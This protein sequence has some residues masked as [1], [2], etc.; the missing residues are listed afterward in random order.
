[1]ERYNKKRAIVFNT[2]QLYRHD[3]LDFIKSSYK[4][5]VDGGYQLGVKL[6]RGAY[7]EKENKHAEAQGVKSPIQATK[8][9]TDKD[10]DAALRFCIEHI[11]NIAICAGTHN[12]KSVLHLVALMKKA[13]LSPSDE[14][15]SV[16]QLLGMSDNISFNLAEKGYHVAK[17]VPYGKVSELLPYLTRRAQ[18]NSSVL[19]QSSRELSLLRSEMQRRGLA[20]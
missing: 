4:Q 15:I 12:E 2:V 1:M 11:D 14:R 17:Y 3:R 10:Y 6:V 18:E 7:L 16:A 5:A 8:E 13:G 19:G 20:N 9:A